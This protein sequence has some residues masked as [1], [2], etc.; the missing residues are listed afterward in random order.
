MSQM[1]QNRT[2]RNPSSP[3]HGPVQLVAGALHIGL[4][5]QHY[6]L[7]KSSAYS[8]PHHAMRFL[9]ANIR[10]E[11]PP[12]IIEGRRGRIAATKT[13]Y[14]GSIGITFFRRGQKSGHRVPLMVSSPYLYWRG[15]LRYSANIVSTKAVQSRHDESGVSVGAAEK[16]FLPQTFQESCVFF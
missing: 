9:V 14:P 2:S 4:V 16:T 7:P 10:T 8:C 15:A 6:L 13:C 1:R 12:Q 5:A 11:A 3:A